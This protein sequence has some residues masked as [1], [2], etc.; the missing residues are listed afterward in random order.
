MAR[1]VAAKGAMGF[2]AVLLLSSALLSGCTQ[3]DFADELTEGVCDHMSG[4]DRDH[5][6][7]Y[8]A[9]VMHEPKYCEEIMHPGPWS[10]CYV[11]IGYCG[12]LK[13]QA[14]GDGAYTYYDCIQYMAVKS[15][16]LLLCNTIE[17]GIR[18]GSN[19]LNPRGVSRQTCIDMATEDCGHIGQV[20]CEDPFSKNSL[21][22]KYCVFGKLD[23]GRCVA[24]T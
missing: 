8:L 20:A 7:Q 6:Y 5:C 14:T 11:Y 9:R 18:S 13:K 1:P 12:E 21:T 4:L 22:K 24:D 23:M 2:L 19:D 16:S 3:Y 10:K 17:E 15:H